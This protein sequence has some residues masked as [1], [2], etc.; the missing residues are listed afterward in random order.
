MSSRRDAREQVMKALYAHEQTEG[1]AGQAL[2]TLIQVPLNDDPSTRDFAERLFRE[3]LN[4]MDEAD[5]IIQKHAENW[6]IH[7]IAVIDRCLLRMATTELLNFEEIPPKVSVDEAIE[8]AKAYSTPRSGTFVNGIIDA[9]LLDLYE[10]E[11]LNKSGR[12]LIG[13]DAIRERTDSS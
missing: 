6:E 4:T 13:M 8:I 9:V 2:H 7:R 12:G 1:D 3:T 5:E 11:R 10:Q